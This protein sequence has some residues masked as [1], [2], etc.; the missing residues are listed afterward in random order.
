M[1][2]IDKK[3]NKINY[4]EEINKL[5]NLKKYWELRLEEVMRCN[6]TD[7]GYRQHQNEELYKEL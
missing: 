4:D 1:D 5:L 7:E 3:K 6:K 2:D